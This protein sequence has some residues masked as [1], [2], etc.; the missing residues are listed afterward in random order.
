MAYFK[1]FLI[2]TFAVDV[3][4]MIHYFI[5]RYNITTSETDFDIDHTPTLTPLMKAVEAKNP[6]C[7]GNGKVNGILKKERFITK[8]LRKSS[9][10]KTTNFLIKNKV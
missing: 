7:K 9:T 4:M 2:P 10:R 8:I 5:F 3:K 6:R 1:E